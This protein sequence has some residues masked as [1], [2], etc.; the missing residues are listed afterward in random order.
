MLRITHEVIG[1]KGDQDTPITY[2]KGPIMKSSQR[3]TRFC[4]IDV[5]KDKHAACIIGQDGR[6]V[7]RSCSFGNHAQGYQ[8]ILA[9]LHQ[10][11]GPRQVLI[12]MEATGHYWYSLHDFLIRNGYHVAVLN[13][14][15]TAQQA[16]KAIRKRKTDKIDAAHIAT[17]IK[18]GEHRLSLVP[19]ELGMTCRQLTRLRYTMIAQT[20]R[21]KQ[22]LWARLHPVWPE[23]EALFANPLCRTGRTL[24]AAAPTPADLLAMNQEP[25]TELIRRTSRGRFGPVQAQKIRQAAAH[26]VGMHRGL[27][28]ARASIRTLLTQMDVLGPVRQQLEDQ[29]TALADQLP[30]YVMTLPAADPIRAVSLFGETDPIEAFATPEQL[31]AFAGLDLSVFQTGQYQA[32]TRHISKRGSP[33]LRRT[34]WGMA[35]RA[36]YQE[37]DLREYYLR[38]RAKGLHHLAAVTATAIKYCRISWRVLTDCRDY[39]PQAPHI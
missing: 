16:K 15:Q 10:A 1:A 34:L 3:Y 13:P 24:L 17:L 39:L 2:A 37:G 28:G 21:L 30:G 4:G 33:V 27:E 25:L 31:V 8:S 7:L 36:I 5:A 32:A 9:R 26:S 14:L 12:G 18:N 11:G 19:G 23:F 29:I 35:H 20:T 6:F 38:K 22:L